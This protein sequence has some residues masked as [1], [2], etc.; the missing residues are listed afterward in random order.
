VL[1]GVIGGLLA[2]GMA[3]FDAASAGVYL[4]SRAG[5]LVSERLGDA[6]LLASDL[7]PELPVALRDTKSAPLL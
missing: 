4:H 1:S 6:G 7:L 2:Q 5:M 3:P